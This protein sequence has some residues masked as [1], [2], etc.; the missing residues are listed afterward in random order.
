MYQLASAGRQVAKSLF[1]S[2]SKSARMGALSKQRP[3]KSQNDKQTSLE[4]NR[5]HCRNESSEKRT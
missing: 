2:P 4:S 3:A 1:P 5:I